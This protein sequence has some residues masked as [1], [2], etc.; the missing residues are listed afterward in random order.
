MKKL[1]LLASLIFCQVSIANEVKISMLLEH[2]KD[3]YIQENSGSFGSGIFFNME[4]EHYFK[5][6]HLAQCNIIVSYKS[7]KQETQT[8]KV[9]AN[10]SKY[11]P[12]HVQFS[13]QKNEHI[14]RVQIHCE[15]IPPVTRAYTT[16]PK[17]HDRQDKLLD[18]IHADSMKGQNKKVSYIVNYIARNISPTSDIPPKIKNKIEA[19]TPFLYESENYFDSNE[20]HKNIFESTKQTANIKISFIVSPSGKLTLQKILSY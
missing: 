6:T 18:K 19:F 11:L 14:N 1:F 12:Q 17:H 9:H 8:L 16:R 5:N 13:S 10:N 3:T 4:E 2:S 20:D 7:G 15:P